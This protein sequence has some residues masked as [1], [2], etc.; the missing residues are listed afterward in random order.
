MPRLCINECLANTPS[1]TAQ[2]YSCYHGA[3]L[4]SSH[5]VETSRWLR[6]ILSFFPLFS[7]LPGSAWQQC[8]HGVLSRTFSRARYASTKPHLFRF[9][10]CNP[11]SCS[12]EKSLKQEAAAGRFPAIPHPQRTDRKMSST[13]LQQNSKFCRKKNAK[14]SGMLRKYRIL[15]LHNQNPQSRPQAEWG[16]SLAAFVEMALLGPQDCSSPY[17]HKVIQPQ[18]IYVF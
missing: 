16:D 4:K 14:F 18:W 6:T 1:F 8:A 13:W 11:I 2:R 9:Q 15:Q 12:P 3:P 7:P 10:F 17:S 5:W